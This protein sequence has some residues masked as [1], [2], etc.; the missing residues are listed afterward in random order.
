MQFIFQLGDNEGAVSVTRASQTSQVSEQQQHQRK[1]AGN[2]RESLTEARLFTTTPLL[3]C[4]IQMYTIA[5]TPP[6]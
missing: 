1:E 4:P 2:T 3:L 5:P 6:A